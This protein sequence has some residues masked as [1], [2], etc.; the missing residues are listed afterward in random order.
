MVN[1]VLTSVSMISPD[2]GWAV[3]GSRGAGGQDIILHYVNG[4]WTIANTPTALSQRNGEPVTGL[5][6]DI[7]A[8]LLA[9]QG[10]P[11]LLNVSMASATEGWAMGL[12]SMLHYHEGTW[13]SV[14]YPVLPSGSPSPVPVMNSVAMLS[15]TDGWAVGSP[16]GYTLGVG[17]NGVVLHYLNG[18][19]LPVSSPATP[20]GL[21]SVAMITPAEG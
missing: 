1:G 5:A 21:L 16:N 7:P 8:V 11:A 17:N 13:I 15:P 3:G 10:E 4:A 20:G 14:A 12:R 2:L 18:S 19:W 9:G 6:K